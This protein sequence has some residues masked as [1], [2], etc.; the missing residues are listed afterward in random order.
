MRVRVKSD[1]SGFVGGRFRREGE[2]FDLIPIK[3]KNKTLS[4]KD[5]FSDSWM[6]EVKKPGPAPKKEA[7]ALDLSQ[8]LAD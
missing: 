7:K 1:C 2:E 8:E 6:E 5:Q 4:A 3:G